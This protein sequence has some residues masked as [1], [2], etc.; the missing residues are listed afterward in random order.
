MTKASKAFRR[1]RKILAVTAAGVFS[2]RLFGV[3]E[4]DTFRYAN[5]P[6]PWRRRVFIVA[7]TS[8]LL[9]MLSQ[10]A[11]AQVDVGME[12]AGSIG[13]PDADIRNVVGSIIRSLLGFIGFMLV[14]Q[15]MIAG[16]KYMTHGGDEDAREE[17]ITSIKNA[18]IGLFL[19]MASTSIARFVVNAIIDAT[20]TSYG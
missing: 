13:L 19:I 20:T 10:P 6:K 15:L 14:I 5:P 7:V 16:F 9:L 17:A 4:T 1:N 18:C 11:L 8:F 2:P 12:Y 3:G